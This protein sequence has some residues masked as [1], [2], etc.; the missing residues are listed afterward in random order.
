MPV[1]AH[2]FLQSVRLLSDGIKTF[3]KNCASGIRANEEKMKANLENS[4]MLVTCLSPA[5]GYDK[6]AKIAKYAHKNGLSLKQ[7]ALESGFVDEE[8]FD[9]RVK[10]ENMV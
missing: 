6:A 7:A 1:C 5:I 9:M 3:E 2:N 4:L 8:T 10:P